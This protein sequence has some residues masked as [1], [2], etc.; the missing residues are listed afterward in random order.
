MIVSVCCIFLLH[1]FFYGILY[2]LP[3]Q[4]EL[5][6]FNR[7]PSLWWKSLSHR[8]RYPLHIAHL[9]FCLLNNLLLIFHC[10]VT[11]FPFLYV[12][13][14]IDI[15]RSIFLLITDTFTLTSFLKFTVLTCPDGSAGGR[16]LSYR[17][18]T[19][20]FGWPLFYPFWHIK[21]SNL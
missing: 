1:A 4:L 17:Y 18:R 20:K 2:V 14:S 6:L 10:K 15:N 8:F 5:S 3:W 21:N 19:C 12:G 9:P 16:V 11:P 7:L 13:N